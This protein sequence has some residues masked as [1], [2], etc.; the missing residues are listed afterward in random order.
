[1]PS[2]DIVV[3]FHV[4]ETL[5]LRFFHIG[6]CSAFQ[7]LCFVPGKQALGKGIVIGLAR[8]TPQLPVLATLQ[9]LT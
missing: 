4:V 1:M 9:D 8:S 3:T 2:L 7:Q 5:D 6:K